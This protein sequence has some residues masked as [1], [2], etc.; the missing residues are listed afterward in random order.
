MLWSYCDTF[1]YNFM[2][3]VP[4]T[5]PSRWPDYWLKHFGENII[6]ESHIT[7]VHLLAVCTFYKCK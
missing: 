3:V 7:R 5:S 4:E 6:N 2:L 1:N